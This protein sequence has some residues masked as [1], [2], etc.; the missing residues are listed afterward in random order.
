MSGVNVISGVVVCE[1]SLVD[2][3]RPAL[4]GGEVARTVDERRLLPAASFVPSTSSRYLSPSTRTIASSGSGSLSSSSST[5]LGLPL[6]INQTPR[7]VIAHPP[8]NLPASSP[9]VRSKSLYKIAEPRMTD[10]VKRTN[11][12]GITC[13]ASKRWRALLMYLICM[14]AVPTKMATSRYVTGNVMACHSVYE[15]IDAT[16]LVESAV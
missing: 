15:S 9:E 3:L 12:T 4:F 7:K 2:G 6:V 11:C 1:V 8:T 5:R 10:K 16:P 14:T 13:V